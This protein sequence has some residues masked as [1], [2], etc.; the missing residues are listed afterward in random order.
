MAGVLIAQL[1][2][3]HV[4][5]ARFDAEL[6]R[7]AVEEIADA[8]PDLVVVAGDLTEDGY[9]DEQEAAAGALDPLQGIRPVPVSR[10]RLGGLD[11][12]LVGVDS[13]KPDLDEGEVGR[14]HRD[15]GD[16]LALVNRRRVDLVLGGHRHVPWVWPLAGML[17]VNSGTVSTYRA[18]GFRRPAYNLSRVDRETIDVELRVP[19]GER[20]SVV[21][22][23]RAWPAGLARSPDVLEAGPT[24]G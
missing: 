7:T 21:V 6:L 15:A 9:P 22:Y 19:G 16:V 20:R 3:L 5:G 4:G 11:V 10:E 12:G 2:D 23:P 18:R 17:I 13:S 14:E 24:P 8:E 1:S